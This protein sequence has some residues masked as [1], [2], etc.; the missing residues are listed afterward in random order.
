M[1]G[2]KGTRGKWQVSVE[3]GRREVR[4]MEVGHGK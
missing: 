3:S 2:S 4:G 1:E